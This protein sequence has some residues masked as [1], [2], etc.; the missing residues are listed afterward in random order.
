MSTR[1]SLSTAEVTHNQPRYSSTYTKVCWIFSR[2]KF[3]SQVPTK[4]SYSGSKLYQQASRI[5][6]K[7]VRNLGAAVSR[8]IL[9]H[10]SLAGNAPRLRR[11]LH[12]QVVHYRTTSTGVPTLHN[13]SFYTTQSYKG[14][15][16]KKR[17]SPKS[18]CK[19]QSGRGRRITQFYTRFFRIFDKVFSVHTA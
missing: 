8:K 10:A 13:T 17:H 12:R 5:R 4:L 19:S 16:I 11:Q 7:N 2:L 15:I 14:R 1:T 18:L 6:S 3:I 9:H